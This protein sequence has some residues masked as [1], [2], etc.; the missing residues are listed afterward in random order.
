MKSNKVRFA[1]FLIA[2]VL[3]IQIMGLQSFAAAIRTSRPSTSETPYS[4]SVNPYK[5][6][7]D[8]GGNCTWYAWGRCYEVT[9]HKL[10]AWGDAGAWYQRAVNAG[11]ET[12]TTPRENSIM[13][14][15]TS[16]TYGH[17]AFCESVSGDVVTWTQSNWSGPAFNTV[18][19]NHPGTYVKNSTLHY[20]Y[21]PGSVIPDPITYYEVK[22]SVFNLYSK[23]DPSFILNA[24]ANPGTAAKNTDICVTNVIDGTGE[25]KFRLQ[26]HSDKTYYIRCES[27]ANE[28]CVNAN[29]GS[30]AAAQDG[31]N[32]HLWEFNNVNT[33]LW[34]FEA[35]DGGY[36]YVIRNASN[37]S[38][39]ITADSMTRFGAVKV[40]T[41]TGAD[42]QKWQL[43]DL[44]HV[45][46]FGAGAVTTMNTCTTPGVMTYTCACG[47]KKT[48][49]IPASG[50]SYELT[51]TSATCTAEGKKTYS[52]TSCGNSYSETIPAIG[53]NYGPWTNLDDTQHQRICSND[54]SHIE[55]ENHI[56][57]EGKVTTEP[58]EQVEG[59]KTFTCSVCGAT[60]T[61]KIDKLSAPNYISG[62]INGDRVVN[63]KDLTRL[64]KYLSGEN[65]DVVVEVLDVN[66]DGT[67][68][69]K[70]LTRLMK[71]LSGED[72][73]IF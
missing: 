1:A 71:Y 9:G 24:K 42:N 66:G 54:N 15:T 60:K 49:T 40:H 18:S 37:P 14:W 11:Y 62:D 30:R 5:L 52:C 10:P 41:Y 31:D 58:T 59:I 25:Q 26:K 67:V 45:H 57:D 21:I 44:D 72:V 51:T 36:Y 29:T 6:N 22:E 28:F 65:V 63:S 7:P 27:N 23:Q 19:N 20:I 8:T 13:C 50:H 48:E 68:N 73:T 33:K 17:V 3:V 69:S 53:H 56:W 70:D 43:K 12:G 34:K 2:T 35:V 47:E 61:E 55:K 38:L 4:Y 16:N 46:S 64:M 39:C 32:V